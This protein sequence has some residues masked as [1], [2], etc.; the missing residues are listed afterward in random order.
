MESLQQ[1]EAVLRL[2]GD[3]DPVTVALVKEQLTGRG[4][5]ELDSLR[6]LLESAD[7]GARCGATARGHPHARGARLRMS[8]LPRAAGYLVNM[9]ISKPPPGS[10][11]PLFSRVKTSASRSA[12]STPGDARRS[13]DS[14][15][16]G[17]GVS[18]A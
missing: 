12:C 17:R 9:A 3:D 18:R 11:R 16:P 8:A 10:W 2:L 4:P 14:Q 1:R 7:S 13:T 5:A 6:V 15:P